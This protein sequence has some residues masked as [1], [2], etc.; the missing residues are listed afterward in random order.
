MEN[1]FPVP[2]WK[3]PI[4][5]AVALCVM[6]M[7]MTSPTRGAEYSPWVKEE[8]PMNLYWGD[9]HLHS[10][11]SMDANTMGNT[12]LTPAEA[13]RFA[14]GEAVQASTGMVARLNIPLDF[15]VVSDHAEQMGIMLKL[16]EGDPRLMENPQAKRIHA[17]MTGS[18]GDEAAAEV[19]KEFLQKMAR[20]QSLVDN[21]E[22]SFSVW[23][24]S[25]A[26]ADEYNDPGN[27]TALIGFEWTS[28][29]QANNL[30]RVVVYADDAD[31]AGQ[32]PPQS[33]A[34]GDKPEDL[35]SFMETY[36]RDTKGHILAIPHNGNLS[37]GLMFQTE[38]SSGKAI[39]ASYAQRRQ[40]WEPIVEVTQI[41]GDGET[42]P[43]LSPN[44]E[45][46]DFETWDGGN[47]AAL[48]TAN[49]TKNMLQY[50]YARSA[51]KMGLALEAKTGSNPYQFGMIGSTDSHT[52]LATAAENNFWGKATIMEPGTDRTLS[53]NTYGV[54]ND[55]TQLTLPW[56]YVASGYAGVW[57]RENTRKALF[58][59]MQRREV[60]ATTGSRISLRFFG[61]W[62]FSQNDVENPDSV[63]IGY[64]K[65]VPM[66]GELSAAKG[67]APGFMVTALK[68]PH[69]ANL[70]RIQ[71]VKGWLDKNGKLQEK[72]Y[73]VALSN[74]REIRSNGSVSAL[75]STVDIDSA[76]YRNSTGAPQLSSYWQD[77]DFDPAQRAFYYARV[78]EISTP[79][80]TA[81]D[82]QRLGK[83]V[84]PKAAM[85]VQD[86][87]YSSPIW[88]SPG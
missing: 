33:S 60:Y 57:A 44:D 66:G 9:T 37:N 15:L 31:K 16:R 5:S 47:F 13:Y 8:F 78:I 36:E 11:Y 87:A 67:S 62:E 72:V 20:G 17:A 52:S 61:G 84:D 75:K 32:L 55:N 6:S 88:Y 54:A 30:H 77:P 38:D 73:N 23:Q 49:K 45:F 43:F 21:P 18:D 7:A 26:A 56:K 10:A 71:L 28:M 29:P 65:G 59:A 35:W 74:G 2:R 39:D 76:S 12:G 3:A 4:F 58:E 53:T 42:H 80:W 1:V 82:A 14:R 81:Y 69:G 19:M 41:K 40:R 34:N 68:D 83:S 24:D 46:A 85:M 25:I 64:R 27:F 48:T 63:R 50:E 79:R 70:D 51:L 86:R 22:V